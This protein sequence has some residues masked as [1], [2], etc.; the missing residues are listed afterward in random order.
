[1]GLAE[2]TNRQAVLEAIREFDRLGRDRFLN[3]YGFG[4]ARSYLLVHLPP[5]AD[6]NPRAFS[7]SAMPARVDTP[8]RLIAS[9]TGSTLAAKR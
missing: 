1:M 3:K 6:R 9:M 4:R 7:A 2:I 5:R 8:D